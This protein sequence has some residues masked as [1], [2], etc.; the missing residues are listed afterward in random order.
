MSRWWIVA[1]ITLILFSA[2]VYLLHYA[3]FRDA[4]NI[5]TFMIRNIAFVPIQVLLIT[6]IIDRLLNQREKRLRLEKLN[7]VIGTFFSEVGGKLLAYLSDIDPDLEKIR[8]DLI[9]TGEWTD[10]DFEEVEK[11]LKNYPYEIEEGRIDCD[12]IREFLYGKRNFLLR[13]LENPNLL[14]HESFT[15]LLRAVFHAAEEFSSRKSFEDIPESDLKH[16]GGDLKR[17]YSLLVHQWVD[18]MKYLKDNYPYLFSLAMRQN[19]F[20]EEATPEVK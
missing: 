1:S 17:V 9:I 2:S 18:Y 11:R 5:F 8:K 6:L 13:L 14:E 3:I 4:H 20:D 16:L 12:H 15:E 7:M 10:S 19:P